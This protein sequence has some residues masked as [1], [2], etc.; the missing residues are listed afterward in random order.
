MGLR[1]KIQRFWKK[2]LKEGGSRPRDCVGEWKLK[3]RTR[4]GCQSKAMRGP[5]GEEGRFR[6]KFEGSN[7]GKKS[8]ESSRVLISSK[9]EK[10][11][12]RKKGHTAVTEWS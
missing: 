9:K 5:Q 4:T 8:R 3:K 12:K 1:K 7:S 10:R 2:K 6:R 11:D